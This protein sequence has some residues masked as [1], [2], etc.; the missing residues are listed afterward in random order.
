MPRHDPPTPSKLPCTYRPPLRTWRPHWPPLTLVTLKWKVM[1]TP[2]LSALEAS[3]CLTL[4]GQGALHFCGHQHGGPLL[5]FT[6]QQ[7]ET[8]AGEA[9]HK[10]GQDRQMLESLRGPRFWVQQSQQLQGPQG[11]ATV[12]G[13]YLLPY[14]APGTDFSWRPWLSLGDREIGGKQ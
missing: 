7:I 11:G 3:P 8:L 14:E 6:D 12:P 13:T 4:H 2:R 5:H 1:V 9:S 10:A